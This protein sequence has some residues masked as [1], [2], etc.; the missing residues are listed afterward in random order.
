MAKEKKRSKFKIYI[1]L[2]IGFF[3]FALFMLMG[4]SSATV[5]T[6]GGR[7]ASVTAAQ[8]SNLAAYLNSRSAE[9]IALVEAAQAELTARGGT[10]TKGGDS[11]IETLNPSLLHSEESSSA[12]SES[13][14]QSSHTESSTTQNTGPLNVQWDSYFVGQMMTNAG[15]EMSDWNAGA[16]TFATKLHQNGKFNIAEGYIPREGD[17]VFWGKKLR[18]LSDG[19]TIKARHCGI[20]T[21]V[22]II[23]DHTLIKAMR[24]TVIE[25]DVEGRI[26]N[27][28][29]DHASAYVEAYIYDL[30]DTQGNNHHGSAG[31]YEQ[32][33]G[34]G[35]VATDVEQ[36]ESTTDTSD[37]EHLVY[38]IDLQ[39]TYEE[40]AAREG[41][42]S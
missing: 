5:S 12:A 40:A 31:S 38:T 7:Q 35:T 30:Y 32:I 11:Y 10:S 37:Y 42:S 22:E 8:E 25:G 28:N 33:M 18:S 24:I 3:G 1:I 14:T 21:K 4:A 20:V 39:T 15:I 27:G 23:A 19:Q 26:K 6:E 29:Y 13:S 34:Y 36:V 41:E 2:T 17:I 9:Q 16:S